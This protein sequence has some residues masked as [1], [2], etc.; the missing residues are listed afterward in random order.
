M[1]DDNGVD[2]DYG[3][4]HELGAAEEISKGS[5]QCLSDRGR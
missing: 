5:L 2:K 3:V 4:W 1:G